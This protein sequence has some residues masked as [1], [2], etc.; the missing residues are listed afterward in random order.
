MVITKLQKE[1]SVCCLSSGFSFLLPQIHLRACVRVC[2]NSD[3]PLRLRDTAL[4][5]LLLAPYRASLLNVQRR[6]FLFSSHSFKDKEPTETYGSGVTTYTHALSNDSSV[7][8]AFTPS[9]LAMKGR[10]RSSSSPPA[11]C[12]CV[13]VCERQEV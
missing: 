3:L 8:C 9:A 1:S 4:S 12:V 10:Q 6:L 2:V 7:H 11:V 13:C 5:C